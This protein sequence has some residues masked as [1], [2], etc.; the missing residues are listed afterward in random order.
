MTKTHKH[1]SPLTSK[2]SDWFQSL[3]NSCASRRHLEIV[4][5][6]GR[7]VTFMALVVINYRPLRGILGITQSENLM[8]H[9]AAVA[10]RT[11]PKNWKVSR[12]GGPE[13]WLHVDGA[14]SDEELII[15]GDDVLREMSANISIAGIS[16]LVDVAIG[17]ARF[18]EHAATADELEVAA[19]AAMYAAIT[20]P[21]SHVQL[22]TSSMRDH[23]AEGLW[24]DAQLN[25]ALIRNEFELWYQPKVSLVD[26][27][28]SSV[29]ALIRWRHPEIGYIAPD[30]FIPR[31]ETTGAI[32]QIGRWVIET[33]AHQA[34]KWASGGRPLRISVN[35]SA[36][37]VTHDLALIDNIK[38]AQNHCD[39]LIDIELTESIF[40]GGTPS[41]MA[42]IQ[43]CRKLG[44][45]I[46]LDDFGSGYSSLAQ[47]ANLD[48]TALKLDRAFI[49]DCGNAD[50]QLALLRAVCSLASALG[51]AV[52]AEGV[53]TEA[54]AR[55]LAALGVP[56]AQGWHYSKALS[57]TA[58][59]AWLDG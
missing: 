36:K 37:Q 53:E 28:V 39:S 55:K 1:H 21:G 18:P 15:I 54:M 3:P 17:F 35:V 2:K 11:L 56:Y 20:Q 42:F 49:A 41:T 8:K 46:H 48:L 14:P 31:A 30:K 23:L 52:I 5:Q 25:H 40:L 32:V 10:A 29:E 7:P 47:L 38:A 24:I 45:G 43:G 9:V 12:P 6:L 34:K 51:L 33:A 27:T 19:D 59:S 44:C 57:A 4:V 26:G 22:Y 58:L 50:R 13:L 16:V